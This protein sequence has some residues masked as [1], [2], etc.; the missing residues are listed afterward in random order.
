MFRPPTT[1]AG[2]CR[3]P[4]GESNRITL[5]QISDLSQMPG[6]NW[7]QF[8][9]GFPCGS[10]AAIT[11]RIHSIYSDPAAIRSSTHIEMKERLTLQRRTDDVQDVRSIEQHKQPRLNRSANRSKPSLGFAY[12]RHGSQPLVQDSLLVTH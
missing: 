7:L 1:P 9:R 8:L 3:N 10:W 11:C 12:P 6:Q 4:A 2:A 5:A